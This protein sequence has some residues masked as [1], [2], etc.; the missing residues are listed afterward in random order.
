MTGLF[1]TPRVQHYAANTEGRDFII[2]DLHGCLTLLTSALDNMTFN[3]DKDRLFSVGDLV[4]RGPDNEACL[5]LLNEPW[6]FSV[7]GNHDA[8]LLSAIFEYTNRKITKPNEQ[9][10]QDIYA[11]AFAYN[12]GM[13]WFG[14]YTRCFSYG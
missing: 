7:M 9:A 8:M 10:R 4:D 14:A 2:G 5:D 1:I 12:G 6:F 3:P 13:N 11:N